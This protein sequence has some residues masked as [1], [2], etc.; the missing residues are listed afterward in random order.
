MAGFREGKDENT[1]YWTYWIKVK[2]DKIEA[3]GPIKDLLV[4]FKNEGFLR[5]GTRRTCSFDFILGYEDSL[6]ISPYNQR[7]VLGERMLCADARKKAK[8]ICA[9]Y[10]KKSKAEQEKEDFGPFGCE[11]NE[12]QSEDD[13]SITFLSNKFI[14]TAGRGSD[15]G[16]VHPNEYFNYEFNHLDKKDKSPI[17]LETVFGESVQKKVEEEFKSANSQIS[18]KSNLDENLECRSQ[19]QDIAWRVVRRASSWKLEIWMPTHRLCGYGDELNSDVSFPESIFGPDLPDELRNGSGEDASISPDKN[20][21]I[22]F[23]KEGFKL[24]SSNI[25]VRKNKMITAPPK[26]LGVLVMQEWTTGAYVKKWDKVF[27]K[28]LQKPWA[29]PKL[30]K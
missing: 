19:F 21:A 6:F 25:K 13:Q 2:D 26:H 28:V 20:M 11:P 1:Q 29:E 8:K 12:F 24:W 15:T 3:F 4:P 7:P 18:E 14:S 27:K 23:S 17:S 30:V 10:E 22:I 5:V 16:G 9:E